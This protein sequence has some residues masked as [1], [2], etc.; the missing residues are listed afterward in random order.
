MCCIGKTN[1]KNNCPHL[2]KLIVDILKEDCRQKFPKLSSIV[3]YLFFSEYKICLDNSHK[4]FEL[5]L[6]EPVV[7][8]LQLVTLNQAAI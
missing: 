8:R 2:G 5:G 3:S 4:K 7:L 6:T 1:V